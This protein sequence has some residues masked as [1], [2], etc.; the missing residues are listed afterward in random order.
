[1][2]ERS[3][4]QVVCA[5]YT[6]IVEEY[7]LFLKARQLVVQALPRSNAIVGGRLPSPRKSIKGMYSA[8]RRSPTG[9]HSAYEHS[10]DTNEDGGGVDASTRLAALQLPASWLHA[11][12]RHTEA[13]AEG[14][15]SDADDVATW[16]NSSGEAWL[17]VQPAL[18]YASLS[19][20]PVHAVNWLQWEEVKA[21]HNAEQPRRKWHAEF[22]A[23]A[24]GRSPVRAPPCIVV[25]VVLLWLHEGQMYRLMPEEFVKMEVKARAALAA[26]SMRPPRAASTGRSVAPSFRSLFTCY[27]RLEYPPGTLCPHRVPVPIAEPLLTRQELVELVRATAHIRRHHPLRVAYRV[28]PQATSLTAAAPASALPWS[29]GRAG[30]SSAEARIA[31]ATPTMR[32]PPLHALES[33]AAMVEFI[34]D[35]LAYGCTAVQVVA[36]RSGRVPVQDTNRRRPEAVGSGVP[37]APQRPYYVEHNMRQ[38]G[39]RSAVLV[40]NN[41]RMNDILR[42]IT[43]K[44]SATQHGNVSSVWRAVEPLPIDREDEEVE[45]EYSKVPADAIHPH[46][47]SGEL[48]CAAPAEARVTAALAEAS[49]MDCLGSRGDAAPSSIHDS[50]AKASGEDEPPQLL[51]KDAVPPSLSEESTGNITPAGE[52]ALQG[53]H[54]GR[55][56]DADEF[57]VTRRNADRYTEHVSGEGA[58][59]GVGSQQQ[60]QQPELQREALR[61]PRVDSS[62][63]CKLFIEDALE[64][65][66]MA[67][68]QKG[69]SAQYAEKVIAVGSWSDHRAPHTPHLRGPTSSPSKTPADPGDVSAGAAEGAITDNVHVAVPAPCAKSP[70]SVSLTQQRRTTS[71][72]CGSATM[73]DPATM[74]LVRY[75]VDPTVVCVSGPVL[76]TVLQ[77][78]QEAIFQRC[79]AHLCRDLDAP[80]PRFHAAHP[81]RHAGSAQFKAAM[82][83]INSSSTAAAPSRDAVMAVR[84]GN[85]DRNTRDSDLSIAS[86]TDVPC[87]EF[88]LPLYQYTFTRVEEDALER[89]IA[90]VMAT[91]Q[92]L[93]QL[94]AKEAEK[95]IRT[96]PNL[97]SL[98]C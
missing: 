32:A 60:R 95:W 42:G 46:E 13:L 15:D 35:V 68:A 51:R 12:L 73:P 34:R 36:V 41:A 61:R 19:Y 90:E 56:S 91:Y 54:H 88:I 81:H 57:G 71:S 87:T 20:G 43:R 16:L 74:V 65:K 23:T 3:Q 39:E 29:G 7:A 4:V 26:R 94:P 84:F 59:D 14:D 33:D 67:L 93:E 45:R 98:G 64:G 28:W 31:V 72:S 8:S 27:M 44:D 48:A 11:W 86:T 9:R 22:A 10:I 78:L 47:A 97:V 55:F 5:P 70:C 79:C 6:A 18:E 89:C 49:G 53:V 2:A 77:H 96:A 69:P 62:V 30:I 80:R 66:P 82:S 38:V 24:V 76:Q 63:Q 37:R 83:F 17:S 21:L 40:T 1:M 52:A 85:G 92:G 75:K 50:D 58:G 25:Q